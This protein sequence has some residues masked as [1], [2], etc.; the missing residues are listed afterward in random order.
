ML[1]QNSRNG[2]YTTPVYQGRLSPVTQKHRPVVKDLVRPALGK[3]RAEELPV[4]CNRRVV[5]AIVS[6]SLAHGECVLVTFRTEGTT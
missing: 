4:G 6:L 5:A 1:E 2:R 3:K